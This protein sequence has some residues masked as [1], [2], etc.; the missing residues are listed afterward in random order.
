[1]KKI[2]LLA[3]LLCLSQMSFSQDKTNE[4]RDF[5]NNSRELRSLMQSDPHRP[6]YHFVAPEGRAYPFDPNGGIFWN[7]KYHLGYIY[8]NLENG[9]NEHVWGHAVST[10]LFH[11]SLYPDMLNIKEGDIEKGIFSGGAF[12]SKEGVPHIMYHGQGSSTN[13]VAYAT[14]DELK[15]WKK[16]EG[17]PVLKTPV[18]GDL[19]FGKYRAWDPEGWYDKEADAYYQISGGDVAGFFKSKDMLTWDY[20]GDLIDQKNRM[21]HDF[22]DL[23][24]PDFFKIGDKSM[25][26]FISHNLG[27]Q[28]YL[29]EF[30]KDKYKVEKH[31][32]MNWP[33][34]T[35][36][37]PE[38]LIDDQGR[39]IIWGWV[40]ERKPKHLTDFGW[41]GVMS[42]PRVLD[43]SK[44]GDLQINPPK[45]VKA[46][47]LENF[48]E[49]NISLQP[50]IEKILDIKGRSLEIQVEFDGTTSSEYGLKVFSS[51]DGREETVIKYDPK[52]KELVID[53]VKSSISG[54]VKMRPNCMQKPQ[55]SGFIEDVSEQR[56][57]FKLKNGETLKL[58]V[59]IDRSII[60]VFANGVLCLTQVVY[61]E[62][63]ESRN[64]TIY[65][66]EKMKVKKV[67]AWKMAETNAY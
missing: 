5:I 63:E 43:L 35:F 20:L 3:A 58:D 4:I 27:T 53:F 51:A 61:P 59:F 12:L 18:D 15:T 52:A 8:Q 11:W 29:G 9:K 47:R 24:C 55:L 19:M 54:P 10:D 67:Q 34:G 30:G 41:S 48:I 57:P 31:G 25:L 56:A 44:S 40:L 17:N 38:Q 49:E 60:E 64:V 45:E 13:L 21:R 14:D 66:K 36:F 28:Y 16:F 22:E 37:A 62:L 46:L 26:L 6:I 32:R 39:N 50:N 33:G 42:M 7:G 1:M 65:S 23:S 2:T